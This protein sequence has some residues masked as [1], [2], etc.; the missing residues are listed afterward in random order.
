MFRGRLFPRE[1]IS[2]GGYFRGR[3]VGNVPNIIGRRGSQSGTSFACSHRMKTIAADAFSHAD[4]TGEQDK[5]PWKERV[6]KLFMARFNAR[7]RLGAPL[8]RIPE[9]LHRTANQV[10]LALELLKDFRAG[11]YR[12]IPWGSLAILTGALLYAVNPADVI[13]DALLGIGALDDAVVIAVA[14]RLLRRD[15]E[16]YCAYKGYAWVDYFASPVSP[17]DRV[18]GAGPVVVDPV[19][20]PT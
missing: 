18:R 9:S 16:A 5:P 19:D 6:G 10:A 14:L 3:Y 12:E 4:T 15:L 20:V 2:A 13:P 7:V 11:R 1:V 17:L 8:E